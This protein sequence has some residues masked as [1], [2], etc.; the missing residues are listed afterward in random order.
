[1]ICVINGSAFF[2]T[3]ISRLAG[4]IATPYTI[5]KQGKRK[6]FLQKARG[7]LSGN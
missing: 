6:A 1:M 5:R 4:T 3:C 7:E 2:T